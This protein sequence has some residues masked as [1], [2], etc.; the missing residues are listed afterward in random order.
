MKNI[1]WGGFGVA[2]A[3]LFALVF[4]FDYRRYV[5]PDALSTSFGTVAGTYVGSWLLWRVIKFSMPK[6]A[7]DG[8]LFVFVSACLFIGIGLL[9]QM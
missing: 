1:G 3:C 5:M 4:F 8:R 2:T 9:K 6:Y 7:P